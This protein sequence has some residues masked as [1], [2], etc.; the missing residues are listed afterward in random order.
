MSKTR[1]TSATVTCRKVNT[2][3]RTLNLSVEVFK[4]ILF[5]YLYCP[6]VGETV[7]L[8]QKQEVRR[9]LKLYSRREKPLRKGRKI[10][11]DANSFETSEKYRRHNSSIWT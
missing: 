6:T 1:L 3:D 10:L 2:E 8:W 9:T 11:C 7:C 4:K 5:K